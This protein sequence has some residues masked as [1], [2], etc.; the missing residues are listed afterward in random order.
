MEIAVIEDL[1]D[2]LMRAANIRIPTGRTNRPL[3]RLVPLEISSS[4]QFDNL[5]RQEPQPPPELMLGGAR[6][7]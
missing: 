2:G 5:H 6:R 3:A 4:D 1:G 7:E